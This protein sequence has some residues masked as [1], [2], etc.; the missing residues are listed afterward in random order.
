MTCVPDVGLLI[1]HL[2]TFEIMLVKTSVSY[3]FTL[4]L[5]N[6]GKSYHNSHI[7]MWLMQVISTVTHSCHGENFFISLLR[8]NYLVITRIRDKNF[9]TVAGMGHRRFQTAF[10]LGLG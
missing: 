9:F 7:K 1:F 2:F 8:V 10:C 6:T 4:G 3:G 5:F